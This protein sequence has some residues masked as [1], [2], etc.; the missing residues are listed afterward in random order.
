M[1]LLHCVYEPPGEGPHPTILALHGRGANALDLLGLA[2]HLADGAFRVICPQG[3]L[4]TPVG[5]GMTGYAWFPM[6]TGGEVDAAAVLS[7]RDSLRRLLDE[8]LRRYPI[9]ARRLVLLGFSQGGGMAYSLGL[10][11]PG[12]FAGMC[13]LSSWLRE[14]MLQRFGVADGVDSLRTLVHHG[15]RDELIEL[16]RA[17]H[18]VT[19]LEN[20]RVPVDYRE[21]DMGHEITSPSL[22]DLS[23]WLREKVLASPI[24]L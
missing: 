5:P 2:P 14:N 24:L 22:A 23:T 6:S 21:Y 11:E 4:E 16:E 7:S 20:L 12:R 18:S 17:K 13:I 1:E 10:S 19:L 8:C 15:R 3:P 9:D